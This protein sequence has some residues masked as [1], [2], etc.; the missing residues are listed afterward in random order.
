MRYTTEI[1]S[2]LRVKKKIEEKSLK[3]E[4]SNNEISQIYN[5]KSDFWKESQE[6]LNMNNKS[7]VILKKLLNVKDAI[8]RIDIVITKLQ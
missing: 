1:N 8:D 5:S 6:G 3:L 2:L 4:E 7:N